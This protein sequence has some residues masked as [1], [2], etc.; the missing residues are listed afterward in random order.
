[1][2]ANSER[3]AAAQVPERI[4]A[5]RQRIRQTFLPEIERLKALRKVN[6]NVRDDEIAFFEQQW[7]KLN[8]ML[9]SAR[10]RLD[11]VRVIVAT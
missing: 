8:A 2:L 11:A 3:Q 7:E 4:A 9:D 6:P 1:M 5:A 10:L